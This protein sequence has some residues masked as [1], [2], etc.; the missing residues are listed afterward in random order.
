MDAVAHPG[1]VARHAAHA[2]YCLATAAQTAT[3]TGTKELDDLMA[4]HLGWWDVLI[5]KKRSV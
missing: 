4:A 2:A 5:E 1:D 3:T